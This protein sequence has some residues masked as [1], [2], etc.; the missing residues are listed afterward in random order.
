MEAE[1]FMGGEG[2]LLDL[3]LDIWGLK[4]AANWLHLTSGCLVMH[5]IT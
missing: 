5:E 4:H 1:E 2:K 3:K